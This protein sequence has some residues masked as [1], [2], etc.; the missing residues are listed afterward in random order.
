MLRVLL[1]ISAVVSTVLAVVL[2]RPLLYALSVVLLLIAAALLTLSI[3]KR[4]Q[5]VPEAYSEIP[6]PHEE[7]LASLGIMEIKPKE[8]AAVELHLGSEDLD[9]DDVDV[10]ESPDAVAPDAYTPRMAHTPVVGKPRTRAP[11]ARIM[12][13]EAARPQEADILIPA[14]RSLRA[15]ID[16][17]TVC[18]L[19]QE[20]SPLRY[21]VDVMVSQ[22]SYA[23]SGGGFSAS[24][25]LLAGHRALVPIVY[26]RVG[27]NGFPKKKLGYYHEPINVRQVAMVPIAP[28]KHQQLFIL[29][30]DTVNDGGL[31]AAPVRVLLEQYARLISTILDTAAEGG[32]AEARQD[33]AKPR[34][35]IIQEEMERSRTMGHELSLALMFL[36]KGESLTGESRSDQV[37]D[38]EVRFEGRLREVAL[39]ARIERFG[40]LTYGVFYHGAR[41]NVAAWATDIQDAFADETGQLQGGVSIGVAM[42]GERHESPD[43]LRSHA[44][45]ALQEAFET[46]EC[47]IVE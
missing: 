43:D 31:E 13:S 44:T 36:N 26:P 38:L 27:P 17:Y 28:K 29:A 32:L 35:D 12:V 1:I 42:L 45:S 46:G 22:N 9:D 30:V 2:E 7:D 25:P 16:A 6:E 18:L 24:E 14:L 10:D 37:A 20:E 34:R 8:R 3:R 33:D 5:D 19:R 47:T 41:E 4:H 21:H 15:S 23:R 40:E 11:R 39:D